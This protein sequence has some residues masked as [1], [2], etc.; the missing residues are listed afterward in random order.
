MLKDNLI[1]LLILQQQH[2]LFIP[3]SAHM[4]PQQYH[5]PRTIHWWNSKEKQNESI[6]STLVHRLQPF[7]DVLQG[8]SRESKSENEKRTRTRT[9][10]GVRN[11]NRLSGIA[12]HPPTTQTDHQIAGLPLLPSPSVPPSPPL[13]DRRLVIVATTT[14]LLW[15]T[16]CSGG[17]VPL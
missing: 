9:S 17:C 1:L 15:P 14:P 3:P 12:D 5:P 2:P 13:G 11:N 6:R 7:V 4:P 8:K 10:V 16:G